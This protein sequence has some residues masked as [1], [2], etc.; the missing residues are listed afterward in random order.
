MLEKNS[1]RAVEHLMQEIAN[2]IR[3]FVTAEDCNGLAI[4]IVA[5]RL[6]HL[7]C[8]VYLVGEH[9]TPS[10]IRAGDL[11]ITCS[12]TGSTVNVYVIAQK[13]RGA[14]ARIIGVTTQAESLLGKMSDVVIKIVAA[15]N[16]G[17]SN[18]HSQQ[19]A[20]SLF[21]QATL[22]LFDA[23]FYVMTRNLNENAQM[24][25]TLHTSLE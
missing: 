22:L 8:Q 21:E 3:I 16:L 20:V 25:W 13:A 9:I 7:G 10:I 1:D 15:A 18:K 14:G 12:E 23:L 19:F 2:A 11:L 17:C 5:M 4:R 24:L 6:M